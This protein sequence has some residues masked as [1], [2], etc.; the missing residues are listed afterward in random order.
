MPVN[1]LH[2]SAATMSP[3]WERSRDVVAGQDAVKNKG[4]K[5]LP[6][7][8]AHRASSPMSIANP[9]SG[10]AGDPYQNYKERAHF[11]PVGRRTVQG[12]TGLVFGHPPTMTDVSKIWEP[13]FAD[14]TLN[15]VSAA[16]FAVDLCK[17]LLTVSR[18]GILVDMAPVTPGIISRPYWSKYHAEQIVNWKTAMIN[19]RRML[20]MLVLYEQVE[21]VSDDEFDP[22]L[23]DQWRV[24]RL[25]KGQYMVSIYRRAKT[26]ENVTAKKNEFVLHESFIPV[27]RGAPL[28]FIPFTFIGP[29]GITED[30][31]PP[32]LIDLF[33][34]NLSHYR[35][36]ADREHG[37]HYTALPTPWITG[38]KLNTGET[39][40]VGGGNA[41]V[42]P[43]PSAKAGMLEFTGKGL[44]ALEKLMEEKRLQMISLGARMLETQKNAQEAAVT[45]RLRHAGESSALEVM[46]GALS[47]GMSQ[48]VGQHLYWAGM[49]RVDAQKAA[50]H[51]H[52]DVLDQLSAEDIKVL[53]A[54][55]QAGG[56]SHKTF[57]ENLEWGEWTRD[58]VTFEE[59]QTDIHA[60][61]ASDPVEDID[62]D[63]D[64]D[65]IDE[66]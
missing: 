55:W 59:E 40:A 17:E 7:L 46:A 30:V 14:V 41:W 32:I 47:Q 21:E 2:R 50:F 54:T 22:K 16:S 35:T 26:M 11:Y 64:V 44:E 19:G 58:G 27:R 12:L 6:I 62:D 48:V 8:E 28:D 57:Y 52:P 25:V 37:A 39:L 9:N 34:T 4:V 5:Y 24:C 18:V 29:T 3:M 36:S 53:L 10:I 33:D 38:H 15:G 20:V 56:I 63:E 42:L 60:E 31:E 45:V 49:D 66:E 61:G 43:N 65:D 23:V 1:S 51:L 13:Q